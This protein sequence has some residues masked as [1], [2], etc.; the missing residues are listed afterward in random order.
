MDDGLAAFEDRE[1][2]VEAIRRDVR[3]QVRA[4]FRNYVIAVAVVSLVVG[5]IIGGVAVRDSRP[6]TQRAVTPPSYWTSVDAPLPVAVGYT[7][8]PTV[9]T[10]PISIYV[11]GAVAHPG[12]VSVPAGSLLSVALDAAGG[13]TADAD[14]DSINLAS[15]LAD[16]QHIVVPR[17]AATPIVADAAPGTDGAPVNIN[18]ASAAELETLP[19]IGPAMAQRIIDYREANGPF[20]RVE[21]LQNVAG[22]GETRYKDLAPLITVGGE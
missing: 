9:E 2:V 20:A 8:Q 14:L 17:L 13:A 11:T 12:V 7:P 15:P 22:I 3:A 16:N 18:T 5:A 1:D 21:D 19:H 6:G 10:P 4:Q